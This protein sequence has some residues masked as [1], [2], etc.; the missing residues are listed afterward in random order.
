MQAEAEALAPEQPV[1]PGSDQEASRD[2]VPLAGAPAESPPEAR[3]A[4][5][6]S[7]GM[8]PPPFVPPYRPGS[9][10]SPTASMERKAGVPWYVWLIGGCLVS[11]VLVV[12]A[13]A[14][15]VG[16]FGGLAARFSNLQQASTT[17]TR[18]FAVTS[19]PNLV[20][21]SNA[22]S[23]RIVSG[24]TGQVTVE[25]TK[26]ARAD[27]SEAAQQDLNSMRVDVIQNGNTITITSKT[28]QS[29]FLRV[30]TVNFVVTVPSS[31][32]VDVRLNAGN[33]EVSGVTGV[34]TANLNAG[35][36]TAT[37]VLFGAGSRL[38]L[39]VGN[40]EVNGSL[41]PQAA[42]DISVNTG[43][44]A[45]T[46]PAATATHIEASTSAGTVTISGWDITVNR[47]V[48]GASAVGDT[49][50]NPTSTLTTRVN[51]GNVTISGT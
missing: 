27:S 22:G 26:T 16:V 43:N 46:L 9:P 25:A 45:V 40:I 15:V 2:T 37:N 36:V 35:N 32:N 48:P 29:S 5:P 10:Y 31:A 17:F 3:Q 24:A 44:V 18:T 39:N 28:D 30:R 47:T 20:I 8:Q 6:P 14:V 12:L 42:L 4:V 49:S 41:S 19:T 23:V 34:V 11:L 50:A 51:A 13:C 38:H 7:Y 1:A 33:L 21:D